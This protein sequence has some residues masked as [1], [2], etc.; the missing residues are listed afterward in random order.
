MFTYTQII[1]FTY[2]NLI[3]L[4]KLST[5]SVFDSPKENAKNNILKQCMYTFVT[6]CFDRTDRLKANQIQEYVMFTR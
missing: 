1:K 5:P 3:V 4:W 6:L 2:N